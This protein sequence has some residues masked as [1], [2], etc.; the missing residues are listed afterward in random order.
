MDGE[1]LVIG[2]LLLDVVVSPGEPMRIDGDVHAA[3][4]LLPCG[5]GGNLAIR[6]ARRGRRVRL[7]APL[8]DDLHGRMLRAACATDGVILD[9]LAAPRS[10]VVVVL[11]DRDGRRSMLSDRAS[12]PTVPAIGNDTRA[13]VCSSYALAGSTGGELAR[14]LGARSPGCRLV[15]VGAAVA[16]TEAAR[17]LASRIRGA[18]ADLVVC[19]RD[20]A[21]GLLAAGDEAEPSRLAGALGARLGTLAI[22]TDPQ[23]GSAA[24]RPDAGRVPRV[25]AEGAPRD[26]TGAGDAYVAALVGGLLDGPWPPTSESLDAAMRDGAAL[27]AQVVTVVGA[28]TRVPLEGAAPIAA[29]ER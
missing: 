8:G 20:E 4:R 1:V 12:S 25:E 13:I 22:V 28:Q 18:S 3:V 21:M 11:V 23:G 6:L 10:G 26:S 15:I 17:E 14:R 2:D 9:A 29:P 19:N 16:S 7:V 5:G 24:G 27:A